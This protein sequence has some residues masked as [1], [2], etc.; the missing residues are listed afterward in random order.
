MGAPF[1][2]VLG[3][4]GDV[5]TPVRDLFGLC[6]NMDVYW[7]RTVGTLVPMSAD[8][9]PDLLIDRLRARDW[10]LTAQR[11]AV[12]E[13]LS[14]PNL[15]LTADEVLER[16]GAVLPEISRA[17]VYNT[18]TELVA[19]GEITE[20]ATDGRARRYDPNPDRSH[21]HLIC[22]RCGRIV[23]VHGA[24]GSAAAL[25]DDERHGFVV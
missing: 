10:R 21:R 15:H 5:G 12:A 25:S 4:S 2:C 23:D 1:V 22:D 7:N 17:T 6:L 8:F 14:G 18:L 13:A 11:R 19:M 20:V 24:A 3:H 9:V 16:A